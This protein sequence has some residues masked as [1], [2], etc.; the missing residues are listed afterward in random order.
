MAQ[1]L[2]HMSF[3]VSDL[4]RSANFYDA[5]LSSLGFVRVWENAAAVGYGSPGGEDKF[6]IKLKPNEVTIPGDGFHVAFGALS[7]EAVGRFYKLALEHGGRD[8]GGSGFH[9]EYGKSYY[10]AFVFDPDGYRIEAVLDE[11]D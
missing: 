7:Q 11:P 3:A 5:T 9:P 8:N 2:H 6:A 4:A 10:A 1:M